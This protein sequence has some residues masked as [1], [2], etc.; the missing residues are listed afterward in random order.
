MFIEAGFNDFLAK[1]IDVSKLDEIIE[2]WL[3]REKQIK[4]DGGPS[5]AA[6]NREGAVRFEIPGVDVKRGIAMTGG[7]MEGYKRVLSTFRRD[8]EARLEFLSAGLAESDIQKFTTQVHALKSAS[9]NIGAEEM[10]KEAARLEEAARSGGTVFI[11]ERIGGFRDNLS[12][13]VGRIGE[14]LD[15]GENADEDAGE[16]EDD[17]ET[18]SLLLRLKE[19]FLAED[20][21]K[22]DGILAALS[23]KPLD[24]RTA[25][26]ISEISDMV[27]TSEFERA[28]ALTE[29][30]YQTRRKDHD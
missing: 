4:A 8:A 30:L 22:A 27:L 3:P 2:K 6:N 28:L 26:A 16:A 7:T 12:D 21:R 5:P 20:I 13:L 23:A 10:S 19:V 25:R 24:H 1:P 11:Q 15:G 17:G 9:A 14:T 29:E 18:A